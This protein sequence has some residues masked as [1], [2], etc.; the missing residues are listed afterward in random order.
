MLDITNKIKIPMDKPISRIT[1]PVKQNNINSRKISFTLTQNGVVYSL[2]K[3]RVAA[4]RGIKPDGNKIYNDCLIREN[5]IVYEITSETIAVQ[6]TVSCELVLFG[7]DY[8]EISSSEFFIEVHPELFDDSFIESRNEYNVLQKCISECVTEVAKSKEHTKRS[9]EIL[10]ATTEL[11]EKLKKYIETVKN[12][13]KLVEECKK[14]EYNVETKISSFFELHPDFNNTYLSDVAGK[15]INSSYMSYLDAL[16]STYNKEASGGELDV[17]YT[18][19]SIASVLSFEP[20]IDGTGGKII[21]IVLK[22][23]TYH[24][25]D[26]SGEII[27]HTSESLK[28]MVFNSDLESIF[29][30]LNNIH[31]EVEIVNSDITSICE[32][33]LTINSNIMELNSDMQEVFQSVSDGKAL[34]ASAITDRGMLTS[35][36]ATYQTMANNILAIGDIPKVS[37]IQTEIAQEVSVIDTIEVSPCLINITNITASIEE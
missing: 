14:L 16:Y 37:G 3:V 18:P 6:G 10:N 32:A 28:D 30:N 23:G 26:I 29:G 7:E 19:D 31:E 8:K 33:I 22:E 24:I 17:P 15:E 36:D 9:E 5:E 27:E 21:F 34:V 1:V 20:I 4:V 11:E 13:E 12:F 25:Y 35:S 2:D